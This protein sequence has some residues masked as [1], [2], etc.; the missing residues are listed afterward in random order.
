MLFSVR[1]M[2]ECIVK[3]M[4]VVDCATRLCY[5]LAAKFV[6]HVAPHTPNKRYDHT[7]LYYLIDSIVAHGIM[8]LLCCVCEVTIYGNYLVCK[9]GTQIYLLG[10]V[11]MRHRAALTTYAISSYYSMKFN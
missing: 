4:K 2:P 6:L 3:L 9:L 11:V 10:T 7:G 1:K 8:A 5:H